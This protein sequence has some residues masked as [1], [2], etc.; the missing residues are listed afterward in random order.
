M[1]QELKCNIYIFFTVMAML[2]IVSFNCNGLSDLKKL[3][4]IFALCNER[5]YDI[6]CLQ[7]TFW[8]DDFIEKVKKD[9]VLWN[10]EI[11]YSNGI[12]N[13]Q[14]VAIMINSKFK[15]IFS[16][17]KKEDGRYIHLRG[18]I[19]DKV[20]DIY[21][22]Y[23][24]NQVND[25]YNFFVK[26]KNEI[27]NSQYMVITGDFNTTLS[28]LD[29]SGKT[30]HV[31]D[32]SV[33]A[34]K[35]ILNEKQL[36]D[37]WR[38]RNLYTKVYSRKQI[39]ENFLTQSRIDYFLVSSFVKPYIKN[40]YYSDTSFSDHSIVNLKI[41][42]S[43]VEKGPGVWIFNNSFLQ[44]ETVVKKIKKIF[45][46]EIGSEFYNEH[47]LIWWNNLKFRMKRISQIY[48]KEKQKERNRD[49]FCCTE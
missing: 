12:G 45:E 49:F 46:D 20:L 40:V 37:V 17:V 47:P 33:L 21:N 23:A 41:D 36:Y 28:K 30:H 43:D 2:N 32:K 15:N 9:K 48:G 39:V 25:K 16:V 42:F 14:G 35:E 34:L 13:R 7:E 5:H 3:N 19:C 31:N 44:E 4:C 1:Y 38:D 10:G 6:V 18:N 11:F 29:R 27:I 22:I 26:I 8:S 24:P